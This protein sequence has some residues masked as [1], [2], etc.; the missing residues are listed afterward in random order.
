MIVKVDQS[1]MICPKCK[2]STLDERTKRG[3]LVK[4]T[5]FWLPIKRYRCYGCSA[6]T[7]V[8]DNTSPAQSKHNRTA[9]L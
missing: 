6:K 3:F 1:K 2:K 4:A 9:V 8:Y 5:L 7:Y